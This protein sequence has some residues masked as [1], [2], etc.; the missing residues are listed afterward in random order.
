MFRFFNKA[1]KRAE[2]YYKKNIPSYIFEY[3]DKKKKC[4]YY[5]VTTSLIEEDSKFKLFKSYKPENIKVSL[6]EA[7]KFAKD[8][9]LC[10]YLIDHI[11]KKYYKSEIPSLSDFIRYEYIL[12]DSNE[13]VIKNL[14]KYWVVRLETF[15][16][17]IIKNHLDM[18]N[19][20]FDKIK[21]LKRKKF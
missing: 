16:E 2:S 1:E 11:T 6:E 7:V 10:F 5:K 18:F 12:I 15:S 19:K 13:E 21:S 20:Q 17:Y 8:N 9:K 14:S 3:K 4:I